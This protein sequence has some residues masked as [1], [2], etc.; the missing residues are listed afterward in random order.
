MRRNLPNILTLSRVL[1]IPPLVV[2]F[3]IPYGFA[4]WLATLL[5]LYACITDFLDGYLA[6][7]WDHMSSFGRF[8]DPVAD[9]LLVC[10]TLL[11]LVGTGVI[12]GLSL[13]AAVVILSREILV[14]GLREFLAQLNVG[15][16]VSWLAKWKTA[17]QMIAIGCLLIADA[18]PWIPPLAWKTLGMACLWFAAAL[19]LYTGYDY[20]K[21][22]M[23]QMNDVWI[24]DDQV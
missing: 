11:M 1:V 21:A 19:T 14:S 12:R 18:G 4:R 17:I 23:A 2:S 5:F 6:R 9:K 16:P 22:A 15:M 8:L 7:K 10:S 24:K 13:L 3:F 20:L